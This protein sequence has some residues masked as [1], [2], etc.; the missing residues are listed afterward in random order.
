MDEAAAEKARL[1]ARKPE[2]EAKKKLQRLHSL[3]LCRKCMFE[4]KAF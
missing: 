4:W 2:I 3:L 1:E